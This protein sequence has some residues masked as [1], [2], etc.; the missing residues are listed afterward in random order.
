M[1]VRFYFAGYGAL[2]LSYSV[3][4]VNFT[5]GTAE[6]GTCRWMYS[7]FNAAEMRWGKCRNQPGLFLL[8]F[9]NPGFV[10]VDKEKDGS[11]VYF[12]RC[13]HSTTRCPSIPTSIEV[14]YYFVLMKERGILLGV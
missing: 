14:C 12:D 8:S 13:V 2:L 5:S 11:S 3:R 9:W 7:M 10:L 1:R 4:D 6:T